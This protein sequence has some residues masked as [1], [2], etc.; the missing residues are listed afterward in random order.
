MKRNT[1]IALMAVLAL[2]V[3]SC[4]NKTAENSDSADS[5][6]TTELAA[7][8]LADIAG[9]MEKQA[10]IL[11][12]KNTTKPIR[13][14]DL[15]GVEEEA[16]KSVGLE[17]VNSYVSRTT[18][19]E[20]PAEIEDDNFKGNVV[21][22]KV[23]RIKRDWLIT[24]GIKFADDKK[25]DAAYLVYC[26]SEGKPLICKKAKTKAKK[27]ILHKQYIYQLINP[28]S[29][30]EHLCSY[31]MWKHVC[32]V[33]VVKQEDFANYEAEAR[34]RRVNMETAIEK[35]LIER[36]LKKDNSTGAA[37]GNGETAGALAALD[38]QGPVSQCTWKKQYVTETY[39]F[40]QGGKLSTYGG[41]EVQKAFT[42]INYD[43]KGRLQHTQLENTEY[44]TYENTDYTYG[45]DG[46]LKAINYDDGE[47]YT[48]STFTRDAKT[49]L[50]TASSYEDMHADMG[51]EGAEPVKGK[52][53][54]T[55][56]A[57][58]DHGNWTQ[59][60]CSNSNGEK[61][62]ETRTIKYF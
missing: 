62:T 50:I 34:V 36:D 1:I 37:T 18:G 11:L 8:P 29:K 21:I 31:R 5:T 25:T 41:K 56:T 33:K 61:W 27:A 30:A 54:Y 24:F 32:K 55:Y 38:L 13:Y 17:A 15:P 53:T 58:D 52:V 20:L 26:D 12:D 22:V 45:S 60:S 4:G 14:E 48:K 39:G 59:R 46:R 49:G 28:E 10:F 57:T 42:E 51:D 3:T 44:Y 23:D 6:A 7:G 43:A 35:E 9:F 40:T 16:I 47:G 2:L 19:E